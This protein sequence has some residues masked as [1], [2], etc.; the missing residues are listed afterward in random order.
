MVHAA[1][2]RKSLINT[3]S[4]YLTKKSNAKNGDNKQFNELLEIVKQGK[5]AGFEQ[6]YFVNFTKCLQFFSDLLWEVDPHYDKIRAQA[7][8]FPDIVEK[9]LMGFNNSK[10]HGHS[11][12]AMNTLSIILKLTKLVTHLERKFMLPSH[13]KHL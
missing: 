4:C 8:R 13:M 6:H 10:L 12:K 7:S 11:V 5:N 1:T 2:I 9:R 3:Q